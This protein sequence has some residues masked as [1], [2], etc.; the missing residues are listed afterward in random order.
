MGAINSSPGTLQDT[1]RMAVCYLEAFANVWRDLVKFQ[2]GNWAL[3]C[4]SD[5]ELYVQHI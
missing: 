4:R 1:W 5:L 2:P 3:S